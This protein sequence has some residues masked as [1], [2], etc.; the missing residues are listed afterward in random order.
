MSSPATYRLSAE[1]GHVSV[2]TVPMVPDA[3]GVPGVVG[4]CVSG[5]GGQ[6]GNT[7]STAAVKP[8]T[9]PA[10]SRARTWYLTAPRSDSANVVVGVVAT[11]VKGPLSTDR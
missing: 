1:A 11:D 7:T 3:V 8:E 10:V 2:V 6:G 9:L 5:G 4:G